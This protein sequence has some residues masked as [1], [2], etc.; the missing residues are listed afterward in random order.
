ME[1]AI[2][3]VFGL[4]AIYLIIRFALAWLLRKPRH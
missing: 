4:V 2:W 1:V 3:T